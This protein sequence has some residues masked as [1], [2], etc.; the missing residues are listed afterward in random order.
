M[1]DSEFFQA[2]ILGVVQGIAE[3]LPISS[4]GHLVIFD[5]LLQQ[6]FGTS[7]GDSEKLQLNVALHLGTLFSIV[8]VYWSDLWRLLRQPKL[9]VCI[10]VA[11]IPAAVVGLTLKDWFESL[12]Q[13]PLVAG[14]CLFA[15]AGLLLAGQH[16]ERNELPIDKLTP[17]RALIIGLFQAIALLPGIS[18]SGSTIAGGLLTGL[19]R[20]AATAFSF[21]IAIPAIGGAAVLTARDI[22][23]G[24]GE[25]IDPVIMLAG[26]ITSFVVGL[27]ALTWL[28]RIVTQRKLHW[29]AIYCGTVGLLT[30]IWQ[31][32]IR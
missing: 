12:F 11:T 6:F 24:A 18:R 21:F 30:V 1:P 10:I 3:F 9:I 22:W 17:G 26:M 20:E 27:F 13:T 7:T 28:I 4:S 15:T 8:F 16:F 2:I 19:R 23:K 31:L 25:T 29:F 32:S 14:C 5:A